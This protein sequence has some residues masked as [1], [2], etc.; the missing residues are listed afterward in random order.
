MAAILSAMFLI[1]ACEE[2][3]PS[4]NQIDKTRIL[5]MK[6]EPP[7]VSPG[8]IA[9]MTALV[10]NPDGSVYQDTVAW[11][12]LSNEDFRTMGEGN[13]PADIF[14]PAG[15]PLS[16]WPFSVPEDMQSAYGPYNPNGVILSVILAIQPAT[17]N[18][19]LNPLIGLKSF[20]VSDRPE[21][22]RHA[23]P[24]LEKIEAFLSD[25]A[26]I[27]SDD[28]GNFA[29]YA[30]TKVTL[31]AVVP[32]STNAFTYHWFSTINYK[33]FDVN[34]KPTAYWTAP[35]E[36]GKYP[37]YCVVR[38]GYQFEFKKDVSSYVTGLD[39]KS[40]EIEVK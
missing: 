24:I 39:W 19:S 23:N 5:A 32:G 35:D 17:E 33:R 4:P 2:P 10:V 29:V 16:P 13:I 15:S 31:K 14:S 34:L 37:V 12:V 28:N 9:N 3:F 40:I 1:S 21:S 20:V 30:K 7:E 36:P 25:G 11:G 6:V 22:E 27:Q 18:S 26:Q 38:D 8:E